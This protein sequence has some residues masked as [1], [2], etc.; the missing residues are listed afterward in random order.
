MKDNLRKMNYDVEFSVYQSKYGSRR[1]WQLKR[2]RDIFDRIM[3]IEGDRRSGIVLMIK[4]AWK[5][6]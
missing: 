2:K 6:K 5:E 3:N 4:Q 1:I